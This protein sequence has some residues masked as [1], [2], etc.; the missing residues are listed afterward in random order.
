MFLCF[1]NRII[2]KALQDIKKDDENAI[3]YNGQ[4]TLIHKHTIK[5]IFNFDCNCNNHENYFINPYIP[6][7]DTWIRTVIEIDPYN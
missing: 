2:I 6:S 5:D 3:S 1:G 4:D 7:D